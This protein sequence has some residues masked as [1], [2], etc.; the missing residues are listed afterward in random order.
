[1][2][3][4]RQSDCRSESSMKQLEAIDAAISTLRL[5]S[6]YIQ[7]E[8]KDVLGAAHASAQVDR[9][10]KL[11]NLILYNLPSKPEDVARSMYVVLLTH[12][13]GGVFV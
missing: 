6:L 1:M 12:F 8:R 3:G 13:N 11:L 4:E 10:V 9:S 5:L 7:Q 2:A